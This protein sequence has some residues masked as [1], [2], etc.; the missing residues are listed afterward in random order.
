M[1]LQAMMDE[2][3]TDE[4]QRENMMISADESFGRNH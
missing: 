4:K 3:H 2:Q 1:T